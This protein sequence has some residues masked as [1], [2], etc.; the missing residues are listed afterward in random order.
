[1]ENSQTQ[2][3]KLGYWKIRGL[4]SSIRYLLEYCNVP[5]EGEYYVQGDGP[6]FSR[7]DW[8]SKKFTLNL[9]FP[10]IPYIIDGELRITESLAILRYICKKWSPELLGK[11]DHDYAHV[12]MLIGVIKDFYGIVISHCYGSGDKNAIL[13]IAKERLPQLVKYL[14]DKKYLIGDY[15]TYVDFYFYEFL[16]LLNFISDGQI[17]I[18]Y[19]TLKDYKKSI[20]S[21]DS[22]VRHMKSDQYV[23]RPFNNKIAKINN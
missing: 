12:D 6:E 10:N 11:S 16:E 15:V 8:L 18:D 23:Q 17:I 1:M 2:K 13:N 3:V 14:G 7:D 22:M 21:L 9:D 20:E 19:P 4:A 5:Y